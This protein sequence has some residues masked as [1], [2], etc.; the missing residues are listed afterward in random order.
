MIAQDTGSAIVGPARADIY[1]GAGDEAARIAGRIK[2]PGTFVMLV[3][4]ALDPV[5]AASDVPLPP[6]RPG[7]F[8]FNFD[9]MPDPTVPDGA[10]DGVPLPETKPAMT[11]ANAA[12]STNS[13]P[14]A[15]RRR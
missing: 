13:K 7:L 2:N 9:N 8:S 1:F 5:A 3:P 12:P 15:R 11:G 4:R 14:N 10:A 6:P